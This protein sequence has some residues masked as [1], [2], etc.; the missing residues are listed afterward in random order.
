MGKDDTC[1]N[2]KFLI[3]MNGKDSKYFEDNKLIYVITCK[4]RKIYS[5]EAINNEG[6]L[7]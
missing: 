2:I 6:G 1:V 3:K 7:Y 5:S 4:G